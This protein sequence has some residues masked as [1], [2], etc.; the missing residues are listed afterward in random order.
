MI[1]PYM[2]LTVCSLFV[3]HTKHWSPF[4]TDS[5][6]ATLKQTTDSRYWPQQQCIFRSADRGRR[7][8]A[9]NSVCVDKATKWDIHFLLCP[10]TVVEQVFQ[11][12]SFTFFSFLQLFYW[13]FSFSYCV[14]IFIRFNF[15]FKKNFA[16]IVLCLQTNNNWEV[17]K[18][19]HF[20]EQNIHSILT[21]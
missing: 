16:K 4:T 11:C 9:P 17:V 20:I 13:L 3:A 6:F 1:F 21:N 7:K 2:W 19:R 5:L 14:A 18:Q 15:F 12:V 10:N 8:N